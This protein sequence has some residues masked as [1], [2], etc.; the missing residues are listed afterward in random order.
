MPFFERAMTR[1]V[2]VAPMYLG[3]NVTDY[4]KQQLTMEVEGTAM[5]ED[6]YIITVMRIDDKG[7]EYGMIDHFTGS[8]KYL[9]E[10]TALVFRPFKNEVMD[11]SV[12]SVSE[13]RV[14]RPSWGHGFVFHVMT[15]ELPWA[16][17]RL[18]RGSGSPASNR[19]ECCTCSAVVI[20][21]A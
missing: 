11:V 13:V 2:T 8:V 10:F 21:S 5:N 14:P 15:F 17:D 20:R 4:V 18:F 6:G 7:L 12:T 16:A 1:T 19:S 3:A 9:V